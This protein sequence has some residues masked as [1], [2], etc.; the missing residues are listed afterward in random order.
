MSQYGDGRGSI[1][2]RLA[3]VAEQCNYFTRSAEGRYRLRVT[4]QQQVAK[5]LPVLLDGC[6]A[7]IRSRNACSNKDIGDGEGYGVETN[8]PRLD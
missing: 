1:F 4:D 7:S 6:E 8:P 2:E 5:S 3:R